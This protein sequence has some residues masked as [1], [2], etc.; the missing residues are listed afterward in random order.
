[1]LRTQR[2]Y[3]GS[4]EVELSTTDYAGTPVTPTT[5]TLTGIV[6]DDTP[7]TIGPVV[8]DAGGVG[9]HRAVI[10]ATRPTLI[11]LTWVVDGTWNEYDPHIVYGRPVLTPDELREVEPTLR[12]V[13]VNGLDLAKAIEEAEKECERITGVAWTR[14]YTRLR[15]DVDVNNLVVDTGIHS[16]ARI[17]RCHRETVTVTTPATTTASAV[18]ATT[19]TP[20]EAQRIERTSLLR[21]P[22]AGTYVVGVEHGAHEPEVDIRAAIAMR[23]RVFYQRER[24]GVINSYAE[25]IGTGNDSQSAVRMLPSILATGSPD[26]D[27]VYMRH[28]R[29]WGIA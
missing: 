29:N 21:F 20:V 9:K 5:V 22:C 24:G 2:S 26:V 6:D 19:Y 27:A 18:Y 14:R 8:V 10:T 4:F 13:S 16:I 7:V 1:M 15:L 25:T 3:V 23:A 11:D 28:R 17:G 12:P